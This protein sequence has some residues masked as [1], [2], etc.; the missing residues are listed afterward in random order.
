MKILIFKVGA[1]GDVLM[2]TPLIKQLRNLAPKDELVYYVGNWSKAILQNNPNINRIET[3]DDKIVFEKNLPEL[4]KLRNKIKKEKFDIAFILDRAWTEFV[5]I[6]SCKIPIRIGLNKKNEGW[7]LTHCVNDLKGR[8]HIESYLLLADCWKPFNILHNMKNMELFPTKEDIKNAKEKIKNIKKKSP[9]IC[10]CPGGA[11][12]PGQ[13]MPAR[14]WAKENFLDLIKN[15]KIKYPKCAI[16]LLGGNDDKN[17]GELLLEDKKQT[18]NFIGKTTIGETFEIMKNSNVIISSDI[19]PMHIASASLKPV[20]SLFG[21]TDPEE[22]YPIH[23]ENLV[24]WKHPPCSPCFDNKEYE[25]CGTYICM[26]TITI[27]MVMEKV[28]EAL[29]H[30]AKKPQ[31][32]NTKHFRW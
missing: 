10:V 6:A 31:P 8:H 3:F 15:L 18:Y 28:K 9:I 20:I 12:N 30:V 22:K 17:I 19:G 32:Q 4:L 23:Y 2:T 21:P 16:V 29:T 27:K 1:M 7:S 26:K 11:K 24:I 14:K 25:K 5:F 13:D